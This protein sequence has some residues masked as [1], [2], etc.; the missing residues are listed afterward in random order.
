MTIEKKIAAFAPQLEL[1][2]GIAVIHQIEN[3]HPIYMTKNGLELFG[4][5]LE[6]LVGIGEN[7][8]E[9]YF[10]QDFTAEFF[11]KLIPLLKEENKDET[12]TLFHQVFFPNKD[13]CEWFVASVK[14]FHSENRIPT[15]TL[16]ISFPINDV[17]RIPNKAERLLAETEF[18]RKHLSQFMKL[19]A[20]EKE[21]LKLIAEGK[22]PGEISDLLNIS[23]D[24][25]NSHKKAIK[26]KLGISSFY[27]ISQYAQAFDIV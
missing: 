13:K 1:M 8:F 7:Y 17:E 27:N 26:R 6:E 3:Y 4:L 24:T 12:F 23:I 5:S 19:S 25:V 20:R 9:N 22:N 16:S 14:I 21:V 10:N 18:A 11:E 15:H 2:P